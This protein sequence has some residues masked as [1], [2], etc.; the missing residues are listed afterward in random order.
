MPKYSEIPAW[1]HPKTELYKNTMISK[2]QPPPEPVK[3]MP[4]LH[5]PCYLPPKPQEPVKEPE[6][7][8]EIVYKKK[9]K[10]KVIYIEESSDEE[11]E[12]I[13]YKK[14]PKSKKKTPKKEETSEEDSEEEYNNYNTDNLRDLKKYFNK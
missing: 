4:A 14:K 8:P 1:L 3:G 9:P 12:K 7:E 13:I 2:D 6:P 10:K 11:E 5:K